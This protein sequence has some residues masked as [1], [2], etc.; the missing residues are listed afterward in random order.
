MRNRRGPMVAVIGAAQASEEHVSLAERVGQLLAERGA[1]VVCGGRGGVMQAACRGAELAG[2]VSIGLLPGSDPGEANPH[3]TFALPTGLGQ[4]RNL[5]VVLAAC[6][7][8]AIGG[9]YG[10]LSEIALALKAG[11]R[12]IGLDTWQVEHPDGSPV[13]ILL[14]RTPEA[15]VSL[16]LSEVG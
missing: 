5:L 8:I 4:G 11:K 15:A 9:G 3:V 1:V 16:A 14:A 6:S 10:T 12:V 13:E 2:G 7:V